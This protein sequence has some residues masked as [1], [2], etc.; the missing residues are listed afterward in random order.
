MKI[1][2]DFAVLSVAFALMS[3]NAASLEFGKINLSFLHKT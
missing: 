2:K 3:V 1:R